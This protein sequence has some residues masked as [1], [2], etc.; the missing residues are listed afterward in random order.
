MRYWAVNMKESYRTPD[1][2]PC[3]KP[4]SGNQTS[5]MLLSSDNS[6]QEFPQNVRLLSISVKSLAKFQ[7]NGWKSEWHLL[8]KANERENCS[9][10]T[11]TDD[12]DE[13]QG[14]GE[15]LHIC[16]LDHF[17]CTGRHSLAS[18]RASKPGA[19]P[20]AEHPADPKCLLKH[21]PA[22]KVKVP[23]TPN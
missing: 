5:L 9:V 6:E 10:V 14:Q 7:G 16:Q 1:S 20:T 18:V 8:P 17:S 23:S 3:F 19:I 11:D 2:T 13:P 4:A 15:I 22:W 21:S 12:K